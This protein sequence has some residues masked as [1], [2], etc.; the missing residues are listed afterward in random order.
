MVGSVVAS[1]P[2]TSVL[3]RPLGRVLKVEKQTSRSD[4]IGKV[5][6]VDTSRVDAKFG[7]AKLI[8]E[9]NAFLIQIRC[10]DG[11]N[12]LTRGSKALVVSYDEE[13]RAYEVTPVDDILPSTA[14]AKN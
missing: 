13:R 14:L 8:E 10:D 9:G 7:T 12:Q 3:V 11:E 6:S 2:L 1:V 4:I 5:V